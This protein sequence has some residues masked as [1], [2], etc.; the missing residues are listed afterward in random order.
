MSSETT[1]TPQVQDP[2]YL[3]FADLKADYFK[4]LLLVAFFDGIS[5]DDR[6]RVTKKIQQLGRIFPL[7]PDPVTE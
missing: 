4:V 3:S 7:T 5:S 1:P 2:I 6:L